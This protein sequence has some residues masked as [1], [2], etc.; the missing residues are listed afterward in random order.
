MKQKSNKVTNRREFLRSGLRYSLLGGIAI[1]SGFLG[2]RK[3]RSDNNEDSCTFKLPC[4]ECKILSSC[5]DSKAIVFKQ[6]N[7]DLL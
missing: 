6:I 1:F 3:F 2:W 5:E 7:D 4:K